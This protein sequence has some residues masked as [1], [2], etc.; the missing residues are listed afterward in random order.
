MIIEASQTVLVVRE[1]HPGQNLD[2]L[3]D[4]TFMPTDLRRAHYLLDMLVDEVFGVT[5][6]NPTE[7][8][9]TLFS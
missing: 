9:G 8:T 4:P 1:N 5:S 6:L 2:D 7:E 3:Y